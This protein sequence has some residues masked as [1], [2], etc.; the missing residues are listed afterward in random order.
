MEALEKNIRGC[1]SVFEYWKENIDA[2]LIEKHIYVY[3]KLFCI[4][5]CYYFILHN[6]YTFNMDI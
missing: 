3:L 1:L 6:Y 5:D 4:G 2:Y